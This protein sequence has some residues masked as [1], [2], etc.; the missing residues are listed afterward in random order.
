MGLFEPHHLILII[1]I[2]LIVFGPGKIA[3]LGGQLGRGIRD[4]KKAM[5]EEEPPA[6]ATTQ[7]AP[8]AEPVR[9]I[10]QAEAP[11]AEQAAAAKEVAQSH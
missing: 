1:L 7:A 10:R 4:F 9:E 5:H 11:M 3:D 8:S 2:A 6:P